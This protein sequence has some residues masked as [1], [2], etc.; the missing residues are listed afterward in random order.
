MC[1]GAGLGSTWPQGL[2]SRCHGLMLVGHLL[3]FNL[4]TFEC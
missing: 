3:E 1:L 4:L 2:S